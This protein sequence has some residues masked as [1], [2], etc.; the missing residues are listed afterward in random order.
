MNGPPILRTILSGYGAHAPHI[1]I[2]GRSLAHVPGYI[3][4]LLRED[5]RIYTFDI[6][7]VQNSNVNTLIS[8]LKGILLQ[9]MSFSRYSY[10]VIIL[11]RFE[12]AK[13][14]IQDI[15]RVIVEKSTSTR[16]I[17]L[18][19]VLGSVE[20]GIQSRC[21]RI[22]IPSRMRDI[23]DPIYTMSQ[24]LIAVYNHD[25]EPLTYEKLQDIRDI[26]NIILR[27]DLSIPEF[28][29]TLCRLVGKSSRW[30]N[31]RKSKAASLIASTEHDLRTSYVTSVHLE[32]LFVSLYYHLSTA[33][34]EVDTDQEE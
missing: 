30:T 31:D 1:L 22:R 9:D 5:A 14:S 11:R 7:Q 33:N 26:S 2:Y 12:N 13:K 17:F 27:Y 34:Y 8:S 6:S 16:F 19:R 28:M 25:I 29:G 21:I 24:R 32:S 15:L 10:N 20:P 23:D 3:E 18:T 4:P